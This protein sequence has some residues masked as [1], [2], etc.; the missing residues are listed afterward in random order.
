MNIS[1]ILNSKTMTQNLKSCHAVNITNM[2]ME[3]DFGVIAV[4]IKGK[5]PWN[6]NQPYS[7][8]LVIIDI[9]ILLIR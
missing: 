4:S 7:N 9:A 2:M 8:I 3:L 1:Y 6:G 5:I